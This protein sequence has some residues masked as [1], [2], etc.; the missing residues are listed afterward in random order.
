MKTYWFIRKRYG[1][2]W[3]PASWQGWSVLII[4]IVG[5]LA[6]AGN[7]GFMFHQSAN[8]YET[9]F[10]ELLLYT[11]LLLIICYQTGESPKWQWGN[12]R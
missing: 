5:I 12:K 9:F 8:A 3:Y 11:M 4:Y 10:P 1:W 2:G 6:A 7:S